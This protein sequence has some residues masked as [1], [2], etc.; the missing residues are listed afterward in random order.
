M[1]GGLTPF[2]NKDSKVTARAVIPAQAGIQSHNNYSQFLCPWRGAEATALTTDVVPRCLRG[3]DGSVWHFA[4]TIRK[5]APAPQI[6][7]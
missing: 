1:G 2:E 7:R 3:N 5:T 6:G 4:F